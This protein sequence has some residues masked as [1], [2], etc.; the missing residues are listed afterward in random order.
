MKQESLYHISE[1]A[2]I[3]IFE[4]LPASF[5]A[6]SIRNDVVFAICSKLL[7]NYLLPR[8]CPRVT[9]Y[10]GPETNEADKKKFFSP[11]TAEYIIA[12]ESKWLLPIQRTTLYCYKFRNDTFSLFD[13][14]AGYYISETTVV[15]VS[16]KPI[17]NIMEELLKRNVELRF[18]PSITEL[19]ESVKKSSLKYSLIRMQNSSRNNKSSEV[20]NS[21]E[22]SHRIRQ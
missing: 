2:K 13:E 17:Y 22:V 6:D 14:C 1:D 20:N 15:P 11:G 7:H 3:K 4:P 9:Y 10:A 19:A 16:V 5:Y 8:N 12:V 21:N 18:L